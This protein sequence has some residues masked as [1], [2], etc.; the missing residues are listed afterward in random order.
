VFVPI[1]APG[2]SRCSRR[3]SAGRSRATSRGS[4]RAVGRRVHGHSR[5]RRRAFVA[6]I[7]LHNTDFPAG[8]R[9]ARARARFQNALI[10]LFVR[11]FNPDMKDAVETE[12]AAYGS[13]N[14]FSRARRGLARGRDPQTIVSPVDGTVSE[15]GA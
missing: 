9:R 10:R 4:R 2:S 6:A 11:G 12:P 13:F 5:R 7:P 1:R 15:A 3:R 14:E 8:A